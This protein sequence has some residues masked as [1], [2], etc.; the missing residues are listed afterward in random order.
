MKTLT[1][2]F[3]IGALALELFGCKEYKTEYSEIKQENTVVSQKYHRGAWSQP[4]RIGKITSMIHHPAINRTTFDGDIDFVVNGREIY[5]RF[6]EKDSA[7]VS[8]RERYELV[9]DDINKDG[10]KELI[11][12]NFENYEFVGASLNK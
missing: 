6:N 8:Y 7:I 5:E 10:K 11:Q 12:R 9:Y 2:L 1:K 3:L 4:T